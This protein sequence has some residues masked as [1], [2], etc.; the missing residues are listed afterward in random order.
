[1]SS[2]AVIRIYLLADWTM[3]QASQ[4]VAQRL[5]MLHQLAVPVS[6]DGDIIRTNLSKGLAFREDRD[7][8][9]L[10]VGFVCS[11]LNKHGISA[12]VAM[13]FPLIAR[14]RVNS[15]VLAPTLSRSMLKLPRDLERTQ[16]GCAAKK[17][18]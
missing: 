10:R 8:N 7:I 18:R 16:R 3:E 1:M 13:I 12:A 15:D 14:P 2:L 9:V 4:L 11:L 6:L 17:K 5:P